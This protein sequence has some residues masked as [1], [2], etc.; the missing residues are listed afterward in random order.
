MWLAGSWSTRNYCTETV[1][2]GGQ[3]ERVIEIENEREEMDTQNNERQEG[4]WEPYQALIVLN[5][6]TDSKSWKDYWSTSLFYVCALRVCV[7]SLWPVSSRSGHS[8]FINMSCMDVSCYITNTRQRRFSHVRSE[9]LPHY[10]HTAL[11][12]QAGQRG[13]QQHKQ[14]GAH[15]N[16]PICPVRSES[17][18]VISHWSAACRICPS[19]PT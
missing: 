12:W 9:T 8:L 6:S 11:C 15:K 7:S 3:G 13:V 16:T 18:L 14:A 10:E 1:G 4:R 2:E 17:L 19:A 5:Y